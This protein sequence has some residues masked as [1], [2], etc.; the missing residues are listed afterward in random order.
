MDFFVLLSFAAS[1]AITFLLLTEARTLVFHLAVVVFLVVLFAGITI[2]D[3]SALTA[4]LA[5][6]FAA[7]FLRMGLNKRALK[8]KKRKRKR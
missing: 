7:L 4:V 1:F 8:S 2:N 5:G 3:L 6:Y